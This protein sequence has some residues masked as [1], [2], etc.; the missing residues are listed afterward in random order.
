MTDASAIDT[1]LRELRRCL[2]PVTLEEREEILREIQ[3][4]IRDAAEQGAAAGDVLARLGPP[5]ELAAQYR[6]GLL[7]RRA[8][9]SLSPL[10]LL[11]GALR[12]ATTGMTGTIVFLAALFGYT[13]G[14]G[15]VVGALLK[16][17]FPSNIGV[18][19]NQSR[20]VTEGF[21]ST[22]TRFTPHEILGIWAIPLFLVLG[23]LTLMATTILIRGVL[24]GSQHLQLRLRS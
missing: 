2:G 19:V 10:L 4:H 5:A 8:S 16:P 7:I 14:T 21:T 15:L 6:D 20:T 22:T 11:R 17:F 24:R 9:R 13:L 3:A 23:S 12:I 1:Y 18:W